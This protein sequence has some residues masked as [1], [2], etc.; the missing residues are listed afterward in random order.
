MRALLSLGLA[1]SCADPSSVPDA[2]PRPDAGPPS[3]SAQQGAEPQ[4][5]PA[6]APPADE[7]RHGNESIVQCKEAMAAFP[8]GAAAQQS[9]AEALNTGGYRC[10]KAGMLPQARHL[11]LLALRADANHALAHY[12]LACTL[13]RLRA[14]DGTCEHDATISSVMHHLERAVALDPTRKVRM[15]TDEDLDGLR[16]NL[17]YRMLEG[18]HMGDVGSVRSALRGVT[19]Y[20]PGVG[21]FGSLQ[22]L[23]FEGDGDGGTNSRVRISTRT[24]GRDGPGDP[25]EHRGYWDAQPGRLIV[26]FPPGFDGGGTLTIAPQGDLIRSEARRIAWHAAPAECDA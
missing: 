14:A 16:T 23:T 9:T 3:T 12:N 17:R 2:T 10:Y 19:V 18:V 22:T 24:V 5:D 21:A 8:D 13:M 4:P 25:T 26:K 6:T 11:F 7:V 20:G 1:L 15:K